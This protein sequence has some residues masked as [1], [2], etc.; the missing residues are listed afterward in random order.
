MTPSC[1]GRTFSKVGLKIHRTRIHR[2]GHEP[3]LQSR[4]AR[5]LRRELVKS[6]AEVQRLREL[7]GVNP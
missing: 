4:T 1:C 6:R 7:L 3:S 2:A 5:Q